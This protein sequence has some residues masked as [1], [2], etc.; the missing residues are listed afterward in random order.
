MPTFPEEVLTRTKKGETE[1]RSLIDRGRYVRYRYLHPQTGEA[2]EAR[3]NS[4]SCPKPAE[5]RNTSSSRRSRSASCSSRRRRRG[6]GKSGTDRARSTF[7]RRREVPVPHLCG[8]H[9]QIGRV[10]TQA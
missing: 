9:Y 3:S 8:S 10:E 6:R 2:R 4:S 7:D 5:R 1:V